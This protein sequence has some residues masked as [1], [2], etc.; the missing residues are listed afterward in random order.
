MT[1]QPFTTVKRCSR[2][3]R[4]EG[5]KSGSGPDSSQP[6]HIILTLQSYTSITVAA[7]VPAQPPK[8]SP[9][10]S[11]S[12]LAIT[13]VTVIWQGGHMDDLVEKQIQVRNADAIVQEVNPTPSRTV[14]CTPPEQG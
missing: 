13:E 14:E 5:Q 6:N 9:K 2:K 1:D 10:A 12:A 11:T 4:G 8:A 7:R 3:K